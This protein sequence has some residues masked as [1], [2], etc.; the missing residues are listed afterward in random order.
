MTQRALVVFLGRD[1]VDGARWW[2]RLLKPGFVHCFF[3][4]QERNWIKIEGRRGSVKLTQLGQEP[5]DVIAS[6]YREQGATVI[7]TAV[8]T[9]AV[10]L[11]FVARN[12]VGLVKAMLGV[13]SFSLTPWQLYKHLRG[14]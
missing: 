1:L 11:P 12:C 9:E 14:H 13:R 6:H 7:E 10:R 3:L 5:I 2:S 8:S 4:L